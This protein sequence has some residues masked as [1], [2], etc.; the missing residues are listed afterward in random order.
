MLYSILIIVGLILFFKFYSTKTKTLSP[1]QKSQFT[2]K[3]IFIGIALVV[4]IIAFTKGNLIVGAIA[5]LVAFVSRLAPM[6]IKYGPLIKEFMPNDKAGSQTGSQNNSQVSTPTDMNREQA[7]E[8]LGIEIDA[9]E[10]DIIA[11]HKR[12]IQKMHPDKGGSKALAI[13]INLAKK[14][15]L[16]K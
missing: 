12:L 3:W 10:A 5:S 11:A 8:V 16:G 14:V 7:A 15:L 6:L 4:A 13:Q 1:K 9:N 2:K